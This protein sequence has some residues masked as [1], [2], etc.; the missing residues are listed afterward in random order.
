MGCCLSTGWLFGDTSCLDRWQFP[1]F[2][3]V[4]HP[5]GQME[6]ME[7]YVFHIPGQS[8]SIRSKSCI[9]IHIR[10]VSPVSLH[11]T[12]YRDTGSGNFNRYPGR[13]QS[14]PFY[15]V[16][17][18]PQPFHIIL[19]Q[20]R[21]SD[22]TRPPSPPLSGSGNRRPLRERRGYTDWRKCLRP[23]HGSRYNPL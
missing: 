14:H 19:R 17:N 7:N 11:N 15:P 22:R 6:Q 12:G 18:I 21:I 20:K 1:R 10:R 2:Y 3:Y 23:A 8:S 5:R 16:H 4:F 9:R 13:S